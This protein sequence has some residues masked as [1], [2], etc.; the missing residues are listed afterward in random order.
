MTKQPTDLRALERAAQ[1]GP[2]VYRNIAD[3][4]AWIQTDTDAIADDVYDVHN[5]AFI[6]ALR[7]AAPYLLDVVDA[8][9]DE[10]IGHW[11]AGRYMPGE[12]S[13]PECGECGE[14]WPCPGSRANDALDALDAHLAG[15][16]P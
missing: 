3:G 9:R 14:D 4:R 11:R 13:D 7:N 8:A 15:E 10:G 6:A 2:W 1:P 16:Q 12:P 5:G